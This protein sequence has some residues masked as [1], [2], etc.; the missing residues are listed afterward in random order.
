MMVA[1]QLRM[2]TANHTAPAVVGWCVC[3]F[4][5]IRAQPSAAQALLGVIAM[6]TLR[7]LPDGDGRI[8]D[9]L[10]NFPFHLDLLK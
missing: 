3:A 8:L 4:P 6:I 7:I 5:I 9:R 1:V 2:Y 10:P